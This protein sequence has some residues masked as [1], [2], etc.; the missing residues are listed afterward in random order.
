MPSVVIKAETLFEEGISHETLL[1]EDRQHNEDCK[2]QVG[3]LRTLRRYWKYCIVCDQP[4]GVYRRMV[5]GQQH[6][7]ERA[8]GGVHCRLR[9]ILSNGEELLVTIRS[10]RRGRRCGKLFTWPSITDCWSAIHY[11]R[12]NE[13]EFSDQRQNRVPNQ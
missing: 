6:C 3:K 9:A 12:R 7:L 11:E 5:Q 1:T 4:R 8:C 10:G 13:T 2:K